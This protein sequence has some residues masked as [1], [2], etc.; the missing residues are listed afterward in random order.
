MPKAAL[1]DAPWLSTSDPELNYLV[2]H[3][4]RTNSNHDINWLSSRLLVVSRG[5]SRKAAFGTSLDAADGHS[6]SNFVKVLRLRGME[7]GQ[8]G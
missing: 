7:L 2:S 6:D 4:F 5:A 3:L 8:T 1:Y